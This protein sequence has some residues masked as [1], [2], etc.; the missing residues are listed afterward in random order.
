MSSNIC[1]KNYVKCSLKIVFLKKKTLQWVYLLLPLSPPPHPHPITHI[2]LQG[3][4]DKARLTL[5][6]CQNSFH[7]PGTLSSYWT[8]TCE[9]IDKIAKSWFTKGGISVNNDMW[10]LHVDFSKVK[11]CTLQLHFVIEAQE[12]QASVLDTEAWTLPLLQSS[13]SSTVAPGLVWV[14]AGSRAGLHGLEI[15]LYQARADWDLPLFWLQGVHNS[16]T[17]IIC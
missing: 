10:L 1:W 8:L 3:N 5:C 9:L 15:W 4:M 6:A 14:R 7:T 17:Y 2:Y 16:N 13:A 11:T 12:P